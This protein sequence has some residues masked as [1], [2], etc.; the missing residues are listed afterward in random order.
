MRPSSKVLDGLSFGVE[1]GSVNA[2]VGPSGGGKSTVIHLIL[3][4]YDPLEGELTLGGVPYTALNFPSV[5]GLIGTVS[6]ETQLFNDTISKNITYGCPHD[7]GDEEVEAAARAAQ[8][9]SFIQSFED[10]LQTKVGERGQRLSGGQKQRIAIARCLLR[11]PKLLL[12][13]EATSALDAASEAAVQKALDGLIWQGRHT[14]VL[15]A[16]RLSTVV[17][18]NQIVVLEKGKAVEQGTHTE[19]LA[20]EGV[21]TELV[22]TQLQGHAAE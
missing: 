11:K 13:D 22:Q 1:E 16:H 21:Y 8:A 9:W 3:R 7:V 5:H 6:Q 14:V 12:L 2:L 19:L 15:V 4:F 17:N 10:S 18:S 20:K